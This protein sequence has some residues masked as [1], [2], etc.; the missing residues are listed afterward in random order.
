M[1]RE[2]M[3]KSSLKTHKISI[4]LKKALDSAMNTSRS[5]PVLN[6]FFFSSAPAREVHRRYNMMENATRKSKLKAKNPHGSNWVDLQYPSTYPVHNTIPSNITCS[7]TNTYPTLLSVNINAN[8]QN[9]NIYAQAW[10]ISYATNTIIPH[11][12]KAVNT[13]ATRQVNPSNNST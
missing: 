2:L 6:L 11:I 8:V 7:P 10:N 5:F 1:I 13:R 9:T 12:L 4:Q 3:N